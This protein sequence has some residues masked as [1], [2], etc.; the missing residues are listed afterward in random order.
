MT[1]PHK[2][3]K[4]S[5]NSDANAD[6]ALRL[7]EWG[8]NYGV[9]EDPYLEGLSDAIEKGKNLAVWASN[10]VMTL[11]PEPNIDST[12]G[13]IYSALVL[14]RNVLVFVPVAL[15]WLAVGKATTSFS[16]YTAKNGA[17]SVVNFLQ[18]WQN[19][20]HI[21]A[22]EWTL[23][24]IAQDDFYII[25]TV[26]VLTFFTPFMNRS[27]VKRAARFEHEARRERLALVIE[28]ES[29]LF[30]KRQITPLT[31]DS[32][33]INSLEQVVE[34]TGYLRQASK[35]IANGLNTMGLQNGAW[36]DPEANKKNERYELER[37]FQKHGPE[38]IEEAANDL[39]R[40]SKRV[41]VIIQTLPRG[42]H[43][44][45]EL[46]KVEVELGETR[47]G[48]SSLQSRIYHSRE[49]SPSSIEDE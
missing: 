37:K 14:I 44:R 7:R 19:G 11:M 49:A 22:K 5:K 27:A 17:A 41:G 26:I 32:T 25:A 6:L 48:L 20:Y 3:H 38:Q 42:A 36:S 9:E 46:K 30:D 4:R 29:F 45:K 13:A 31:M 40:V 16:I 39:E 24:H 15:T 18:F 1:S 34:A 33:L 10:D 43:A 21:L 12:E 23:S 8:E 28:V 2:L 47:S 35:R